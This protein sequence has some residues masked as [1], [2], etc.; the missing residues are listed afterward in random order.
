MINP[1][2]IEKYEAHIV[3]GLKNSKP[4]IIPLNSPDKDSAIEEFRILRIAHGS[5][6]VLKLKL[7]EVYTDGG[8]MEVIVPK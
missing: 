8:K 7:M 4:S 2:S 6:A 3:S 5:E 1:E